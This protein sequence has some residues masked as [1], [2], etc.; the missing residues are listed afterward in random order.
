ME[1]HTD[2]RR[3]VGEPFDRVDRSCPCRP[4][5]RD[6]RRRYDPRSEICL[7]QALQVVRAHR[8]PLIDRDL[9]DRGL[10]E[11]EHI[12]SAI[13]REVGLRRR[14]EREGRDAC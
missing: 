7:D 1:P 14:I 5:G 13:D 9:A 6:D 3:D 11:P 2:P 12:G 4:G 8:E 10:A